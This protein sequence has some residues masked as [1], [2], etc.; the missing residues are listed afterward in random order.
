LLLAEQLGAGTCDLARIETIGPSIEEVKF[1]FKTL[2]AQR[3][4]RMPARWGGRGRG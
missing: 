4:E 2:R 1:D 3:R